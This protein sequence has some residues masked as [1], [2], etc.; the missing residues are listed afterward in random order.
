MLPKRNAARCFWVSRKPS[1]YP[2]SDGEIFKIY[3]GRESP[4]RGLRKHLGSFTL[5]QQKAVRRNVIS[6]SQEKEPG[7]LIHRPQGLGGF[8]R[9]SLSQDGITSELSVTGRSWEWDDVSNVGHAG[10]VLD[11]AF[12]PQS[13]SGVRHGTVAS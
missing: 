11:G 8:F 1:L 2:K 13:K 9:P 5:I 4:R 6:G 12:E 10:G 3:A 7:N